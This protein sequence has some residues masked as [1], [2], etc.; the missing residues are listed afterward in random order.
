M[1]KLVAMIALCC[2]QLTVANLMENEEGDQFKE[3]LDYVISKVFDEGETL[4][5]VKLPD[6]IDL[7]DNCKNPYFVVDLTKNIKTFNTWKHFRG[8][9]VIHLSSNTPRSYFIKMYSTSL[10]DSLNIY[11]VKYVVVTSLVNISSVFQEFWSM[12]FVNLVI[13]NYCRTNIGNCTVRIFTADPQAYENNCEK[14]FLSFHEQTCSSNNDITFPKISRK[15]TNCKVLST[16][17]LSPLLTHSKRRSVFY[18]LEDAVMHLNA[19]YEI[20]PGHYPTSRFSISQKN[21]DLD[22]N[23]L[24][25]SIVFR[26]DIVVQ[27]IVANLIVNE[28]VDQFK[29]C[30]DYVINSVFDQDETLGFVK[31]SGEIDLIDNCKNPYFTVDLTKNIIQLNAWK[32]FRSNFVIHLSSNT[33]RSYFIKMYST[34]LW[35]SLNIYYVKY[36]VVTPL[37]NISSVFQEFWSMGFANLVIINYCRTNIENCTVRIIT[38]DPQAYENNCEKSFVSFH[39]QTCSSN[40]DIKFPEISR[41]YTNCKIISTDYSYPSLVNAKRKSVYYLMA[42][43]VKH[44][45]ASYEIIPGPHPTSRFSISQRNF[46]LDVNMLRTSIVFRDDIVVQL[47]VANLI[48]NEEFVQFKECLNYVINSVF[49]QD[50][51]LGF[52]KLPNE[53]DLI[54]NCK[55]PYFVVDLTKNIIQHNAWKH[56]RSNFVIHLS[57]NTPRSYFIKM[58]STS[59]WDSLN[60]YYVK[61]V[62]VT[63]LVNISS[64]FQEFWSM[65]FVNLVIINYCKT[66]I[67]NCTVRIITADPQAYENNCEKSFLSFHEQTCSSNNDI[68]FPKIS[69]KYTNCEVTSTNYLSPLLI[70]SKRQSVYELLEDAVK[71]LNASYEIVP[72]FLPTSRFSISQNNFDLDINMLRTSIVFRDDIVW[73]VPYPKRI[74]A[75]EI[76]KLVFKTNVWISIAVA[77]IL[78][79]IVW[80]AFAKYYSD[81]YS[82]F[83]SVLMTVWSLTLFGSTHQKHILLSLKFVFVTY[84]VYSVHIQTAF[85]SN[86]VDILTTPQFEKSITNLDELANSNLQIFVH[87]TSFFLDFFSQDQIKY[88][89][90]N[91]IKKKLVFK[92]DILHFMYS[93]VHNYSFVFTEDVVHLV[94]IYI[95]KTYVKFIDNTLVGTHKVMFVSWHGSY[96]LKSVELIY[97]RL[98]ESGFQ[99]FI[100]RKLYY[101]KLKFNNAIGH[102][103]KQNVVLTIS[104]LILPFI[105]WILGL[106]LSTLGFLL[107]LCLNRCNNRN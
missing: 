1:T 5:F 67:G 93:T 31:L 83:S 72:E 42:Y 30:L 37:V 107:E 11:Y 28:E 6:E 62:I 55:N 75:V 106:F 85:T 76:L 15:Y 94:E 18:L 87:N 20:V 44:L 101:F 77:Y 91:K 16:N 89:T 43:S 90:F 39:E 45:N 88:T 50:E 24:R 25:S 79:S 66:N 60:I 80:F 63:P 17:Y 4:G 69:R 9:F 96:L 32:H 22:I 81:D 64:V 19:S 33:P 12:G 8:N 41:K 46:D 40:N 98:E 26:D 53:I 51:T 21:F 47:T 49:D 38:A 102:F 65:G 56:F 7:M 74:P 13:I 61:Y 29:E 92:E 105:L 70:H 71:H 97:K 100:R 3:C 86:L 103:D 95:N 36:V 99:D 54:D 84:V 48:V 34:S 104:H 68:T 78:T 23:M 59:L 57:S 14:S 82:S 10:W 2:V 52:V 27:L 35:D 58:Y 73:V